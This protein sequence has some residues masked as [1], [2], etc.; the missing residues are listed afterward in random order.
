M[1]E[2]G[3]REKKENSI[4]LLLLSQV[5][6]VILPSKVIMMSKVMTY[7]WLEW[8]ELEMMRS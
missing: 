4:N 8:Q 5:V 1:K 2:N 7:I 6:M 3:E